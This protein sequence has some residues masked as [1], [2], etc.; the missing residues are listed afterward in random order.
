M[1]CNQSNEPSVAQ[2]VCQLD[3]FVN[4]TWYMIDI[5][6]QRK[7]KQSEYLCK[8]ANRISD[9]KNPL[10]QISIDDNIDL[11]NITTEIK[12]RVTNTEKYHTEIVRFAPLHSHT[13]ILKPFETNFPM[14]KQETQYYY[15]K[16]KHKGYFVVLLYDPISSKSHL[17]KYD[18]AEGTKKS[19][20]NGSFENWNGCR[21]KLS[22]DNSNEK[23]YMLTFV[24]R[25][26]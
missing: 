22:I 10:L 3:A 21:S 6:K 15:S 9:D 8:L 25:V 5:M 13:A 24:R 2:N 1:G 7:N 18:I 14:R 17:W 23:L 16:K 12:A 4:E 26:W 11:E 20:I 19:L